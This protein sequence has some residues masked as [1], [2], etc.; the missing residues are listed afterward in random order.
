ML[1]STDDVLHIT[2]DS[3]LR[4]LHFPFFYERRLKIL[5]VDLIVSLISSE[6]LKE[7]LTYCGISPTL[8]LLRSRRT[9]HKR[10]TKMY[11][12]LSTWSFRLPK[13]HLNQFA[14]LR[15]RMFC[16]WFSRFCLAK[17]R[18]RIRPTICITTI[19]FVSETIIG[20]IFFYFSKFRECKIII[21]AVCAIFFLYCKYY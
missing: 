21:A 8:R 17:S 18:L 14:T 9:I 13:F 12:L 7:R 15:E 4:D 11:T 10:I 6:T 5:V 2:L 20:Y 16:V 3:Y 19:H 1:H